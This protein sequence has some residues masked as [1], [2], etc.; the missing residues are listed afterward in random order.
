M[1]YKKPSLLTENLEIG[2]YINN[3]KK[4]SVYSG[5]NLSS[6]KGEL[7]ALIGQNGIGKSTLLRTL[8]NLQEPL[9]GKVYINGAEINKLKRTEAAR[10]ISFV[11]TE[12]VR[13]ANLKVFDLVALG[14]FPHT[15][16][17]GR[18][19]QYDTKL[20]Q[21][22]IKITGL[23]GFEQKPVSE[24]SDGERQRAMI[25]R[26]LAQETEVMILDEPTAF[27]DLPGKYEIVQILNNLATGR[28][29]SIIFSTHD[30]NIAINRA[31][32]I[33]LML[34]DEIVTGAPEDLILNDR[35]E[36]IFQDSDLSFNMQKGDFLL[37]N[38][39]IGDIGFSGKGLTGHWTKKALERIGF[40]VTVSA[41]HEWIVDVKEINDIIK[42]NLKAGNKNFE[43]SSIYHL[44]KHLKSLFKNPQPVTRFVHHSDNEGG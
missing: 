7:V 43:F 21:E 2:F 8:A 37:P 32:K 17:A 12:A 30:L 40:K 14:R 39:Y 24:I 33:I 11:S 35:F 18:L 9:S 6:G 31:D 19:K 27:L 41:G 25:A 36:D 3:H 22:A 1:E 26:T 15:N 29:K 23:E 5:I 20:V 44:S 34:P 10:V 28:G 38:E 4:R 13:I 42:I 16:W